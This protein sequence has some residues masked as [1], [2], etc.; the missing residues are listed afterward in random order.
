M[1]LIRFSAHWCG[2][3]RAFTPKLRKVYLDTIASGKNLEIVFCSADSGNREFNEYFSSMPW[4]AIPFDRS[5][6]RARLSERF[7]IQGI[8]TL[9]LLDEE[10]GVYNPEGR[11]S[12]LMNPN[13]FPWKN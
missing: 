1:N 3:C 11:A 2:P 5:D 7:G 13:G 6:I 10:Q 8:P 4:K 12:V 9:L